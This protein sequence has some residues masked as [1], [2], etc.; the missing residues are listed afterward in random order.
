LKLEGWVGFR[1]FFLGETLWLDV[2][3]RIASLGVGYSLEL[4][5]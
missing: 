5:D 3:D 2:A 1:N 4:K